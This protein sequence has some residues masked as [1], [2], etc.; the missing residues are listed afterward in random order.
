MKLTINSTKILDCYELQPAIFEDQRGRFVKTFHEDVF[1]SHNLENHF[2]EEYYSVS[3][4]NVIRGLHFQLPP[5]EH[6]KLVYCVS[7]QVMDVVVDLRVGSPTYGQF[8]TFN[9][10]AEKANLIYI[11]PG[12]AHGFYVTSEKAIMMYK[13]ST[14]YAPNEDSGILWNSVDIPWGCDNPIISKRDQSF[15]TLSEFNSPFIYQ[16]KS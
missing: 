13:V 14:V 15:V 5:Q 9:V 3:V 10:S 12:L 16:N 1:K 6:T 8:A 7:G 2:P 11:P 4:K